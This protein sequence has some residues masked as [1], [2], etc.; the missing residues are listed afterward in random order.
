MRQ[1]VPTL[2]L[3]LLGC[4]G[5]QPTSQPVGD[6]GGHHAHHEH[7]GH[8]DHAD[9]AALRELMGA[10]QVDMVKVRAALEAG[11]LA[12]AA[13]H[14]DAVAK[15]CEGSGAP[16]ANTAVYGDRFAEFDAALHGGA[17]ELAQHAKAGD[18][19]AARA[20]FERVVAACAGCHGQ[21]PAAM[22]VDL[23][24]LQKPLKTE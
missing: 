13:T 7:Q 19:T 2:F 10:L 21:A 17:A 15:A 9:P 11:D 8:H 18:A 16:P 4:G 1:S 3:L 12:T 24:A 23:S 14:A 5:S 20:G 6:H 22:E